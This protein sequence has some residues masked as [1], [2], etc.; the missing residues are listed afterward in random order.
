MKIID[1]YKQRIQAEKE[2]IKNTYFCSVAYT[3]IQN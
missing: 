1:T 3:N 2:G